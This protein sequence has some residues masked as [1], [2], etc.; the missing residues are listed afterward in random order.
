MITLSEISDTIKSEGKYW[1]AFIGDSIT[2]CEWVHPNWREIVQYVL[3]D[4]LQKMFGDDWKIPSWGLRCFNFAYDGSTT[5]DILDKIGDIRS[6]NP[7][8]VISLMG[9]NDRKRLSVSEHT[10]NIKKIVG[11]FNTKIVWCNSIHFLTGS[12]RNGK[13]EP[14]ARASMEIPTSENLQL[15][16]M[17]K[18]YKNFP[19]EKFFTFKSEENT[20]E[21]IKEGEIDDTH[22]NQLG[23]AYIA[24]VILKTVFGIEFDPEKYWQ[25]TLAGEKYPKY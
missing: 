3:S 11:S 14:F 23:N 15:V 17:F 8:L 24:K 10:E 19:L 18:I 12:K 16:D 2:S 6:I 1:I 13:Y 22:P 21:G 5:K 20:V 9:S 4:G 7:D 25:E